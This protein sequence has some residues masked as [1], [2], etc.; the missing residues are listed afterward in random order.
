MD[1]K[2]TLRC[3]SVCTFMVVILLLLFAKTFAPK[4]KKMVLVVQNCRSNCSCK[5]LFIVLFVLSMEMRI[6]VCNANR[7]FWN[8]HILWYERLQI[9]S[10]LQ[11]LGNTNWIQFFIQLERSRED[12]SFLCQLMQWVGNSLDSFFLFLPFWCLLK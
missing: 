6:F 1:K 8:Q 3:K 12:F 4:R 11:D 2:H 7:Y 10:S 5:M 9:I